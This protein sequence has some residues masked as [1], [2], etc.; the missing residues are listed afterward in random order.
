MRSTGHAFPAIASAT[1]RSGFELHAL[2]YNLGNFLRTLVLP[3][4]VGH[5]SLTTL[6]EKLAKIG[7]KA[8]SRRYSGSNASQAVR[9][10]FKPGFPRWIA[11]LVTWLDDSAIRINAISSS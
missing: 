4:K 10:S 7:A 1:M 9:F 5:W 3:D 8:P 2:A 6:R 11:K